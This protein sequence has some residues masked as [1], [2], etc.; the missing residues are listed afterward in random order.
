MRLFRFICTLT[1]VLVSTTLGGGHQAS[2]AVTVFG[3]TDPGPSGVVIDS[4]GNAY[5]ANFFA[6][7]VTR[8][9]SNGQSTSIG[10]GTNPYW[11]TV[12]ATDNVYVT[13]FNGD[14]VS[15]IT[16]QGVVSVLASLPSGSNPT[17]IAVDNEGN[18]YTANYSTNTVS[19]ISNTGTVTSLGPT[20][21][22]PYAVTVDAA[23]NVYTA[24]S[25]ADTVTKITPGGVASTLGST[26]A[27][28][29]GIALDSAG[30]VFTVNYSSADISK[31]TPSGMSTVF[32]TVQNQG[33]PR[34]IVIDE[35]DN[36]YVNVMTTGDIYEFS[37]NG[38]GQVLSTGHQTP[39][40]IDLDAVGNVYVANFD[41]NNVSKI[42][43]VLR[44]RVS[45]DSR[46]GVQKPAVTAA[47][48]SSMSDPGYP[49][50][51]GFTFVGWAAT[52]T[53]STVVSFPYA[54]GATS[55]FTLYAVWTATPTS[56]TTYGT[57]SE[58]TV[59]G[60]P[61]A[62]ALVSPASVFAPGAVITAGSRGF[63]PGATV[64][65]VVAS[66]PQVL[67]TGQADA[68]GQIS[69][70]GTMPST[71]GPGTHTLALYE[72]SSGIGFKQS[73]VVS[74][75]VLPTTGISHLLR[76]SALALVL[77]AAGVCAL[78]A[79]RRRKIA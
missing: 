74:S 12:D 54:H 35:A 65:L 40:G 20:G 48:G 43:N 17:G 16:P 6:D 69:L 72:P 1:L 15:K 58:A 23:G 55:D 34:G 79:S 71:L 49:S 18:L 42:D 41:T 44:V 28:P 7:S 77:L 61:I 11:V 76:T 50:R 66:D 32:A 27:S 29:R 13:N 62:D 22:G 9:D 19:R 63:T 70:T 73:I 45:F 8:I 53:S 56:P 33:N 21:S 31:I 4:R 24:D 36:V 25:V 64:Q 59:T 2:A 47:I 75:G 67:A 46:G 78:T 57:P 3:M 68:N 51:D 10:V 38:V 30:N 39:V 37:P 5:T 52:P 14:S 26:G 60:L